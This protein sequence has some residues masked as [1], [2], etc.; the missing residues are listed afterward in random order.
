MMAHTIGWIDR[1]REPQVKPNPAFPDGIDL[2]PGER[3]ACKV[4]LPYPAKRAGFYVVRCEICDTTTV[5]TAAGRPDDP[6]SI[7]L[8][9]DPVGRA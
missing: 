4:A 9:C 2:D 1:G 7:M 6:R 3:P 8:P 5:V